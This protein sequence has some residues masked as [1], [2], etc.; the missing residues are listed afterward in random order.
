MLSIRRTTKALLRPFYR[1]FVKPLYAPT[2]E[3]EGHGAAAAP[4]SW[5]GELY[6]RW[7]EQQRSIGEVEASLAGVARSLQ[8]V[9]AAVA[10]LG[11]QRATAFDAVYLGQERLMTGHPCH[12]FMILDA[13]DPLVTPR[14][15][16]R[17]YEP[18]TSAVLRR[19]VRPGMTVVEAGANQGYHTLTMA[20]LVIPGG[21]RVITFEANP[22]AFAVLQDNLL[23]LG[24]RAHV[25]AFCKATYHQ[26]TRLTFHLARSTAGSTLVY[27]Q[28]F[29]TLEVEAVR[30][31]DVLKELKARPDFVR[32]DVEGAEGQTLDGMWEYLES[33]PDLR[34]VF[35]FCPPLLRMSKYH[36]VE[37][38]LGRLQSLGLKFWRIGDDGSLTPSDARQLLEIYDTSYGDIVAARELP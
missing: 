24:L 1:R 33:G 29:G 6:Q 34:V 35:E 27:D 17:C 26:N 10:A 3:G 5:V 30:A 11:Q 28:G 4:P 37:V 14:V 12:P 38:F 16:L 21:G 7:S 15:I 8:A 25:T 9:Q 36:S 13:Q 18:G 22:R 19:L 23:A 31:G 2:P 32:I 20:S